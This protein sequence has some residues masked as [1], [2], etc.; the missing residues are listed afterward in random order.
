MAIPMYGFTQSFNLSVSMALTLYR[1]AARRRQVL[2]RLGDLDDRKRAFLRAR[3]YALGIRG[4]DA[5]LAR[6]VSKGTR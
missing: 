3:W 5:I 4:L 2:G 1:L 6:H